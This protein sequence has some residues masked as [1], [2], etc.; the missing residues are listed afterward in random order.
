MSISIEQNEDNKHLAQYMSLE[1]VLQKYQSVR[2]VFNNI[3]T[4]VQ[5][6]RALTCDLLSPNLINAKTDNQLISYQKSSKKLNRNININNDRVFPLDT[7][8]LQ[9]FRTKHETDIETATLH[10]GPYANEMARALNLLAFTIGSDIYF[11][12]RG[13]NPNSEE[14]KKILNHELTHVTQFE[15]KRVTKNADHEELEKEAEVAE[16]K[17]DYDPDPCEPYHAGNKV[18][19]LRKSQ[20]KKVKEMVK[21]YVEEWILREKSTRSEEDYL[22]LLCAYSDYLKESRI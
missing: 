18:F 12:D 22:K 17:A 16:T 4:I 3:S 10:I 13:Y 9:Q 6:T 20:I 7:V 1:E 8:E 19:Y 21:Q 14:G 5:K 2:R 15:E 11:R